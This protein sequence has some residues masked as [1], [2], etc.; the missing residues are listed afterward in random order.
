MAYR[1][2]PKSIK[3][4]NLHWWTVQIDAY[5]EKETGIRKT[6]ISIAPENGGT[7]SSLK[8][9]EGNENLGAR[10]PK[11]DWFLI[12]FEGKEKNPEKTG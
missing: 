12:E 7:G 8:R 9:E 3:G 10:I 2:K 4:D 11:K 5:D 1:I 6:Q